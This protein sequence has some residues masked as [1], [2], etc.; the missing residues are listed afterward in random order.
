M[1]ICIYNLKYELPSLYNEAS[2]Y[3]FRA[4]YFL[5]D[6]QLVLSSL[7]KNISSCSQHSLVAHSS[8]CR[9]RPHGLFSKFMLLRED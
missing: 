5:L 7:R 3:V 6:N 8:L 9:V 4:D 2:V 1:C